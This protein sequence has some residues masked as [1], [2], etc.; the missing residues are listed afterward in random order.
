MKPRKTQVMMRATRSKPNDKK[1]GM[2]GIYR[3][4][5]L[6]KAISYLRVYL[7]VELF[8]AGTF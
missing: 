8:N 4:N 5:A 1:Q 7:G 3:L 2:D 6:D